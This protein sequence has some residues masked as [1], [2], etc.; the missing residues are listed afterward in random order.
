MLGKQDNNDYN[1]RG[2]IKLDHGSIGILQNKANKGIPPIEELENTFIQ[3]DLEKLIYPF[4]TDK[5]TLETLKD[6]RKE[7][8][9]SQITITD[10]IAF[11]SLQLSKIDNFAYINF[12]DEITLSQ[13]R[14]MNSATTSKEKMD[15]PRLVEE[16]INTS[17]PTIRKSVASLYNVFMSLTGIIAGENTI[18]VLRT[19][20]M[21]DWR[22]NLKRTICYTRNE[23]FSRLL[24]DEY[25]DDPKLKMH[26]DDP[27]KF[28]LDDLEGLESIKKLKNIRLRRVLVTQTRKILAEVGTVCDRILLQIYFMVNRVRIRD[29]ICGFGYRPFL[30]KVKK[31]I[32][33]YS[34]KVNFVLLNDILG[35]LLRSFLTRIGR[36]CSLK[37]EV[38][39]SF[40][41]YGL[42]FNKG[43]MIAE[44]KIKKD[45]EL[46]KIGMFIIEKNK[47]FFRK[48]CSCCLP[49]KKTVQVDD[50][51][52]H[53][54]PPT[55][56]LEEGASVMN[57]LISKK[58]EEENSESS[59]GVSKKK[60]DI[61]RKKE[62]RKLFEN[63]KKNISEK[64][65][66]N[67]EY[68]VWLKDLFIKI[69]EE[70][71]NI[72]RLTQL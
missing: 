58:N 52:N 41:F 42:V 18:D 40:G 66:F 26:F 54:P 61:M 7:L 34:M 35:N 72:N 45:P 36:N 49:S 59:L 12:K 63:L 14:K 15:Y 37:N 39:L 62:K 3:S 33:N 21:F 23:E 38:I 46:S 57:K 5:F 65:Y 31:Y 16:T 69:Y 27:L 68:L 17:F 32:I 55:P 29:R 24:Q 71:G 50:V 1:K 70:R 10:K 60:L 56:H 28:T 20:E 2:N 51:S 64:I 6:L 48:I 25:S 44:S 47:N 43:E 9:A 53:Q 30:K 67:N 13:L 4:E 11:F 19:K 22:S 8:I